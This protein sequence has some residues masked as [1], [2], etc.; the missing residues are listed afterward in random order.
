MVI[1][2]HYKRDG[3][4]AYVIIAKRALDGV[5]SSA[6]LV[7]ANAFGFDVLWDKAT[8]PDDPGLDT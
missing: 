3:S 7:Y 6:R 8:E 2:R 4:P 5:K 1:T